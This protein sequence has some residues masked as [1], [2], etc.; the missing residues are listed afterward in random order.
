MNRFMKTTAAAVLS[1]AMLASAAAAPA[2]SCGKNAVSITAS[3]AGSLPPNV[4]RIGEY[5]NCMNYWE[6]AGN[7]VI[8]GWKTDQPSLYI[9]EQI[10]NKPVTDI[11]MNAFSG[12]QSLRYVTIGAKLTSLSAGVFENCTNLKSVTLPRTLSSIGWDAFLGCSKLTKLH[13]PYR[14][15]NI[16]YGVFAGCTGLKQLIFH[17]NTTISS[18]AFKN[19]FT[20]ATTQFTGKFYCYPGTAP[21][22]YAYNRNYT[23]VFYNLGDVN[24]DGR[25]DAA[26]AS[27]ILSFYAQTSTGANIP[28]A[29]LERMEVCA[30]VNGDNS[31]D[32]T[33]AS[34]VLGYYAAISTG[35]SRSLEYYMAYR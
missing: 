22:T 15:T 8:V 34:A 26:D 11:M 35:Y 10:N 1:A 14:T 16:G 28:Q 3:A 13:I 25:V 20:N 24:N 4:I 6:Y 30:D 5:N 2:Q 9:P 27:Q 21:S 29:Q 18:D 33:D 12:C 31:V 23:R 17:G 7:V 32:A 19:P